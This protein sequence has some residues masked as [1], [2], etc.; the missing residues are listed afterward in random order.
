MEDFQKGTKI[1]LKIG[2]EAVVDKKLGEG[3]QGAVYLVEYSGKQFALKWYTKQPPKKFVD[4]LE[5][6]I[7]KGKPNE[8]FLWPEILT[9]NYNGSVGYLM[10]LRPP[11]Y[12][13]FS[14]F[15]LAKVR[16]K[17][18]SAM[19]TAAIQ[20]CEGFEEL[21]RQGYSYQDLNDGNFFINPKTGKVLI[22]DND[23]VAPFGKSSGIAGK[24]RYMAPEIVTGKSMPDRHTDLFSLSVT[25]FLLFFNNHPLEGKRTTSIPCMT[26]KFEKEFYGE[27]P[28]FIWDKTDDSNRPVRDIHNN[29]IRR[30]GLFPEI[31]RTTFL[32]AFTKES[33]TSDRQS[34]VM[35]IEWKKVFIAMRN[36][37]VYCPYCKEETFINTN[38]PESQCIDCGKQISKPNILQVGREHL[39]LMKGVKLYASTTRNDGN[40]N[41]ISGEIVADDRNSSL[42]NI[43]NLSGDEWIGFTRRGEQR[44]VAPNQAIPVLPGI[45]ITFQGGKQA[46]II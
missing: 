27:K 13:D 30:W 33:M 7:S 1:P 5:N 15:L 24:A 16:F 36:T 4:N 23:N 14:A 43:K 22:C 26:E 21:H 40:Y 29:V 6:N 38:K 25:L 44:N 11:E 8:A 19:L 10:A 3:G 45:K 31:L 37:L 18:I 46:E 20:I 34:R 32:R 2:G 42:L 39:V 28:V 17:D 35:E 41:T 12:K 9:E